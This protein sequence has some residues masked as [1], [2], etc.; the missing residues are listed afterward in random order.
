MLKSWLR[1]RHQ[2]DPGLFLLSAVILLYSIGVYWFAWAWRFTERPQYAPANYSAYFDKWNWSLYP[3]FFVIVFLLVYYTWHPFLD[4]WQEVGGRHVVRKKSTGRLLSTSERGELIKY[5]RSKR[6]TF[7]VLAFV[8]SLIY[9]VVDT[10]ELRQAYT[11]DSLASARHV[12]DAEPD[13]FVKWCYDTPTDN[14]HNNVPVRQIVF[15]CLC[16]FQ[17]FIIIALALL[18]LW[19]ILAQALLFGVFEKLR[20]SQ[21]ND[22]T[23]ALDYKDPAHE[24]GLHQWN[25]RF[26]AHPTLNKPA[27]AG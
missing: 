27:G 5:L 17:Q 22:F 8:S 23:I 2:K 6:I 12:A 11:A 14:A 7:V 9:N 24:F 25:V 13:F 4:A 3:A 21:E 18:A 15:T 19:Q 20:V 16:Y 26:G 1:E 10:T